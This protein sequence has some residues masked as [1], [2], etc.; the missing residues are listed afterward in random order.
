MLIKNYLDGISY[1]S[2]LESNVSYLSGLVDLIRP[3]RKRNIQY[4]EQRILELSTLLESD[5]ALSAS[6][7][8]LIALLIQEAD[9]TD[10]F[11]ESGIPAKSGFFAEL[12]ARAKHKILPP[13]TPPESLGYAFNRI[14]PKKSD[15]IWV[16][17]VSDAVWEGLFS[18]I[19]IGF[20]PINDRLI[21]QII[22]ALTIVS[23]RIAF[24]GMDEHISR[25]IGKDTELQTCFL[26]QNK[27][28]ILF[29][30]SHKKGTYDTQS[31]R[32]AIVMLNQCADSLT[33]IRKKSVQ[34]GTSL[35][36]NFLLRMLQQLIRRALVL[37]D[38]MNDSTEVDSAK[39]VLFFKQSVVHENTQ[40]DI[41]KFI[42]TTL[43]VLS[44]QIAEH[45]GRTGEHYITTSR[46]EYF[47]FF[48]SS[49]G[50]GAIVS[51]LV[52]LKILLH[53]A[54]L[55]PFWEALSYSLNYAI[56][57]VL[58]QIT[59]STLAT[60]QPAM[61]ASAIASSMDTRKEG[62]VSLFQLAVLTAKVCRSQT[63]S[64]AGNL[65][66][67]FPFVLLW[68]FLYNHTTGHSLVDDAQ[69]KHLLADIHPYR[70]LSFFYAALT[71]FF[72]FLSSII[73]GYVDNQ[74]LYSRIKERLLR[75]FS[76][77]SVSRQPK[78]NRLMDYV[79][80]HSGSLA[81]NIALGFLL[82]TSGLIGHVFGLP[83]DIRH[84]TFSTGN[85]AVGLFELHF[86]TGMRQIAV[87]LAGIAGI[88]LI[89]FLFS[90]SF[91][92]YVAVKSRNIDMKQYALFSSILFRYWSKR[93]L[94]FVYPP[95]KEPEEEGIFG[96]PD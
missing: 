61:T 13:L 29:T 88:G 86:N 53:K 50:G 72:L 96:K 63:V 56:G 69:A 45:K 83:F 55:A 18:K 41:F 90:F 40:T 43:S 9:F 25:R 36:Q 46:S 49:C 51:V 35:H 44:Y 20:E 31:L 39:F 70:S 17:G 87:C 14:F 82:G 3:K 47:K 48:L 76:G 77:S 52:I 42:S 68:A 74:M 79:E 92:F 93:P 30:E 1:T 34:S 38:F 91:A 62:T 5:P 33:E 16:T 8:Q 6:F 37:A 75:K 66:L 58:I 12:S 94:H 27:E 23:Y 60:K 89:N 26:E 65:L 67:V 64:F 85:M 4:A 84:I 78:V 54:H 57:F 19:K 22:N 32:H 80:S 28:L 73:S 24:Y 81:G 2:D 15:H 95:S 11:I 7:S 21:H 59:G 71:G 10:F